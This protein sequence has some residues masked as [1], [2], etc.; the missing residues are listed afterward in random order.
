M[1][2][3]I[4]ELSF[5]G[6]ANTIHDVPILMRTMMNI[7]RELSAVRGDDPI[8]THSSFFSR[9]LSSN[10][11]VDEWARTTF[12]NDDD[13]DIRQFFIV[14][15]RNG[16]FIDKVLDKTLEY[17]ECYFNK[18][19]VSTSS[20]AGAAYFEGTLVSLKDAPEFENERLQ[21]RFSTDSK[22]YQ[23]IEIFNLTEERQ[24]W[25]VIRR[26]YV[27]SPKH[28]PGGWGTPMGL[29]DEVAQ[30]VLD[31]GISHGRQ[32]YGF[33]DGRFYIFQYDNAGGYHGYPISRIDVP[34]N[35][36]RQMSG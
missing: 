22:H 33:H 3:M 4:N 5:I 34:A 12:P 29:G 10:Y 31:N 8:Y 15:T 2:I 19:D 11:T 30:M 18:Q 16:P 6:Q 14:V 26:R 32:I 23:D 1:R 13:R 35:V 20:M 24:L 27:P 36:L 21:V 7:I 28:A 9:E 25:N 17:H